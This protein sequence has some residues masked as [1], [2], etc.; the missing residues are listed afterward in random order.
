MHA[1]N[2]RS[3]TKAAVDEY[4]AARLNRRITEAAQVHPA[5]EQL[6][7]DIAAV[8]HGGKAFR[9]YLAVVG[10]GKL[11]D[12]IIPIAAAQELIHT[13]MLMHDDVIDHDTIRRGIPNMNGRYLTRYT[14]YL[15]PK[16]ARHYAYSAGLLAGDA[17]ISEAYH[18]ISQSALPPDTRAAVADRLHHAIFE[19]LGGELLDVEAAFMTTGTYDPMTIS[20]YKT[21]G[22]S[23]IGP[24][25]MGALCQ[26]ATPAELDALE[27]FGINAGIGFQ[28]QDDLLGVFGTEVETGKST[29]TDLREAKD[30]YLIEAYRQHLA[31]GSE[32][33]RQ[34]NAT[35]GN[36]AATD[37]EL[38]A[39][40]TRIE[41]SGA[42]TQTE[43]Q[44]DIFYQK[45]L[46]ALPALTNHNQA[47][48]LARLI[49]QL[50]ERKG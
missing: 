33:Q 2:L 12:L 47:S 10:Y 9:P 8:A 1:V 37:G 30:T 17:L 16:E 41:T 39:L 13:A 45:A 15:P 42:R 7:K 34:F 29:L 26:N 40:K 38:T 36:L 4:I 43:Q 11:D 3:A 44:I 32:E 31:Q 48:E 49:E 24:L 46:A 20:R 50:K 6:W 23:F 19:V 18:A 22:Y 35:F 14:P 5:Y 27:Q 28:L 25:H 21:A